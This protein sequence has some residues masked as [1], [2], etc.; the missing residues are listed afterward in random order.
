MNPALSTL[1]KNTNNLAQIRHLLQHLVLTI[2]LLSSFNSYAQLGEFEDCIIGNKSASLNAQCA[3]FIVPLDPNTPGGKTISLRV[4]KLAANTSN[5]AADAF[6]LI[7]G[8][9][10]QSALE[11]FPSVSHAFARIRGERD[12]ILMDQRGT[13]ASNKLS[14]ESVE[15]NVDSFSFDA[16]KTRAH[17]QACLAALNTDTR[18]F[19]TSIAVQDLEQLRAALG[20][21]QWNIYGVS[22]GT[23]VALHYAKRYESNVRSMILDA[24]VPPGIVLGPDIAINAQAALDTLFQR[25]EQDDGCNTAFPDLRNETLKLITSLKSNP[26]DV[27]FEDITSGQLRNIQFDNNHLAVTLRLMSYSSYGNA[28]LPSMLHDAYKNENY[29]PLARQARLQSS[30]IDGALASGMH[31]SVVC[32]EDAPF[33]A[34]DTDR[35]ALDKTYL[36]AILLD[37][38]NSNCT[39]WPAGVIDE[40]FAQPL[41]SAIPTLIL[42][43][44]DD[45]ITPPAYGERV[46]E[47]LS[48]SLH[49]INENQGHVQA[50]L[51]CIPKIMGRFVEAGSVDELSL[52]CL[53]RLRAPA[54][55]VDANGPLP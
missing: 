12:I 26:R 31:H 16:E 20:I 41:V 11:S 27:T 24:V 13:G 7:S 52:Q 3:D 25:C 42:S 45:P 51:G 5:P 47:A 44:T 19:T 54:F 4:A 33:I 32:T 53:E 28:I 14:C 37:A 29:A 36:G 34:A 18:F 46:K 43:G 21:P 49:I 1:A 9:P 55:F 40:D 50:P 6:T 35:D 8:G 23:R 22:Y 38:L 10:G 48:H 30:S 17:A 39:P 2:L 15:E